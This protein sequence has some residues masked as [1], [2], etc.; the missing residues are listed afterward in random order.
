[1]IKITVLDNMN[2]FHS[3][4]GRD[5]AFFTSQN[6]CE[7][8]DFSKEKEKSCAF[9]SQY[10]WVKKDY[11][12]DTPE[13][14]SMTASDVVARGRKQKLSLE[15]V[16][17]ANR[18]LDKFEEADIA[19]RVEAVL[20]H[21]DLLPPKF[22]TV[23]DNIVLQ[24]KEDL[25]KSAQIT[26]DDDVKDFSDDEVT[27]KEKATQDDADAEQPLLLDKDIPDVDVDAVLA[28]AE[29]KHLER[30]PCETCGGDGTVPDN[31]SEDPLDTVTCPDC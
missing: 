30:P 24:K 3:F 17:E 6:G 22:D 5:M 7:I 14:Q 18:Q 21:N 31:E 1:M 10:Q 25:K 12:E 23:S 15:D 26:A 13:P 20:D 27:D 9:F 2:R 11:V 4:Q 29:K 19:K 28:E 16:A 8:V